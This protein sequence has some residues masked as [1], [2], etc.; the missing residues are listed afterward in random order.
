M[1]SPQTILAGISLVIAVVALLRAR[2][3]TRRLERLAE[4][5]WEVRYE[6][7]QL[8]AR[9]ARL[10]VTTGVR[11]PEPAETPRP[12]APAATSFIPLASL[13]K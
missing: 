4:S 2:A 8:R 5:Y 10:E 1:L 11:D 6:T 13:K 7:G 3:A 9:I 12:Q